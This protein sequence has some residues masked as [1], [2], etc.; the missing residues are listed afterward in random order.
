LI[1]SVGHRDFERRAAQVQLQNGANWS[2]QQRGTNAIGTALIEKKPVSVFGRQHYLAVNGFLSCVAAPLFSPEGEF[3]G[4]IDISAPRDMMPGM[5]LQL[6]MMT[7]EAVQNRILYEDARRKNLLM[8][9]EL[10]HAG[11]MHGV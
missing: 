5:A 1:E 6:V 3:M 10:E 9:E 2:E 11:R 7:V 4:V 8:V